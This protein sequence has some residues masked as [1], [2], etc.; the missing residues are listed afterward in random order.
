MFSCLVLTICLF[1]LPL[2][3]LARG[4]AGWLANLLV[5][6]PDDFLALLMAGWLAVFVANAMHVLVLVC[7]SRSP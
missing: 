2:F 4:L 6:L 3:L 1:M 5:I 7:D